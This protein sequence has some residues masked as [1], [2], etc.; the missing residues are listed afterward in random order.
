MLSLSRYPRHYLDTFAVVTNVIADSTVREGVTFMLRL[1][2]TLDFLHILLDL[3]KVHL[4][5]EINGLFLVLL[6][7][8]LLLHVDNFLEIWAFALNVN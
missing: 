3:G 2:L 5:P 6:I 7:L 4:R 1:L 8:P